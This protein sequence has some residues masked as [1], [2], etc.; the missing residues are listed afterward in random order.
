MMNDG[1][2]YCQGN[3]Q[4]KSAVLEKKRSRLIHKHSLRRPTRNDVMSRNSGGQIKERMNMLEQAM[5]KDN[6]VKSMEKPMDKDDPNYGKPQEGT[7][8][9]ERGKK[10]QTHVHK[11][12]LELCEVIN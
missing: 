12:I 3:R 9:A 6:F 5:S 1:L 11:E 7:K 8:T 4:E 2:G 10:A